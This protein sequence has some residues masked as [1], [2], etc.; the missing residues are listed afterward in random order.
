[1]RI[2]A[3]GL[4]VA[5]AAMSPV[6][7]LAQAHGGAT[8][9]VTPA[10]RAQLEAVREAVAPLA[11]PEAAARAGYRRGFA[12]LPTMGEHWTNPRL[13]RDGRFDLERPPV[14]M[15]S[16][17]DG[18]PALIGVAYGFFGPKD[19]AL[20]DG[21]DGEAD[22]WHDH[23]RLAPEGKTLHMLHAWLVPSPDGPFAGH[24]PWVA[25]W[26]AGVPLPGDDLVSGPGGED[27]VRALALALGVARDDGW[28]TAP[29][30]GGA[31]PGALAV[32]AE[33]T[34]GLTSRLAE[35]RSEIGDGIPAL[36][37]AIR[38]GDRASFDRAADEAI[39]LLDVWQDT[40]LAAI[41]LPAVR[42]RVRTR[43]LELRTGHAAH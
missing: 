36:R 28:L 43:L 10:A 6:A 17:V 1:M 27:R 29:S 31:R 22:V 2:G 5:L 11:T 13:L 8:R 21:F 33:R 19:A 26:A 35:I 3:G 39:A 18:E 12:W 9:E 16:D 37:E 14:L 32:L 23:D 24:N 38:S 40:I 41:R 42:D 25:Y 15:F 30:R 7:A 4:A 20:P 34:P